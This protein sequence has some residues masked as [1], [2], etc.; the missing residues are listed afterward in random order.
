MVSCLAK[1]WRGWVRICS[2]INRFFENLFIK[3]TGLVVDHPW[4]VIIIGVLVALALMAGFVRFKPLNQA[5]RLFFPDHS[6]TREDLARSMK[7]FP[8]KA[9]PDEFIITM[10]DGVSSVLNNS[11]ALKLALKIHKRIMAETGIKSIC[12]RSNHEGGYTK[13]CF[14]SSSLELFRFNE[15]FIT[16]NQIKPIILESLSND[17]LI[18]ADGRN[19]KMSI[20]GLLGKFHYDTQ[21]NTIHASAIRVEYFNIFPETDDSYELV[22][23]VQEKIINILKEGQSLAEADGMKLYLLTGKLRR[24]LTFSPTLSDKQCRTKVKKLFSDGDVQESLHLQ[25]VLRRR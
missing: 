9:K 17:S 16:D 5:E 4:K 24:F 21:K 25:A 11:K 18:L 20:Q 14:V 1:V 19:T 3:W 8:N 6:T 12:I 23:A 10:A 22:S 2:I 13:P 7:S 15:S